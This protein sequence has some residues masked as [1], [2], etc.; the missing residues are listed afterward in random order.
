ME[1]IS[2]RWAG[3]SRGLPPR[4]LALPE[5]PVCEKEELPR[6][7]R[8]QGACGEQGPRPRPWVVVGMPPASCLPLLPREALTPAACRLLSFRFS[9]FNKPSPAQLKL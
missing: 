1:R 5:L 4:G 2:G 3:P 6:F 8:E 7:P 9:V